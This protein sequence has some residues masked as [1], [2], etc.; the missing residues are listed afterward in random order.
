MTDLLEQA[1]PEYVAGLGVAVTIWIVAQA[2]TVVRRRRRR[3]PAAELP[4]VPDQGSE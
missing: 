3:R 2:A 1:W 4:Q